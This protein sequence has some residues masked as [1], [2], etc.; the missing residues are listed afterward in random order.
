M[1]THFNKINIKERRR[2]LRKNMP[3]AERLLWSRLRG[4][5]IAGY[6]FRRQYSVESFVIDFY[7]PQA[8]L[9][10]EVDGESHYR[11]GAEEYD[12]LRQ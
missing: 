6:K 5:L 4:K 9:A 12:R 7:C 1:T 2:V 3:V 10:I 8:K 11:S